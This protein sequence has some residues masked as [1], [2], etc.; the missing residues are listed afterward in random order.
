MGNSDK[1]VEKQKALEN[2]VVGKLYEKLLASAKSSNS[3][4][5]AGVVDGGE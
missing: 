4:S 2:W 3:A 5:G 1:E